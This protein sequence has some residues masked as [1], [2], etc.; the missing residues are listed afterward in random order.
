MVWAYGYFFWYLLRHKWHVLRA[1][2]ALNVSLWQ[3]IMHDLT[4]LRPKEFFSYAEFFY[5]YGTNTQRWGREPIHYV[6][7]FD[8]RI[9]EA[10]N[11]HQTTNKHHW[12]YWL[13]PSDGQEAPKEARPIPER[14]VREMIADWTGAGQAQGYANTALWYH[15]NKHDML[16][17]PTTRQLVEH[18]LREAQAKGIIPAEPIV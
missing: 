4:K 9:E 11:H 17:H 6:P 1:C 8:R 5:V 2:Q 16:L 13:L 10:K 18:V 15:K 7:G 12:Q 3:A 14:Y